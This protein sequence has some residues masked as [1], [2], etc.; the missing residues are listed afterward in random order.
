VR[1][2]RH[3]VD[4]H[5]PKQAARIFAQIVK[6]VDTAGADSIG[7]RI[8]VALKEGEPL[9]LALRSTMPSAPLSTDASPAS[10][11]DISVEAASAAEFDVL[12]RGAA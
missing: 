10:V 7:K 11:R 1:A 6:V 2:W 12:L 3:L 9:L 8:E 4:E 5:G